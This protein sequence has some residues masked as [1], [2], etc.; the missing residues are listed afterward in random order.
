MENSRENN[1]GDKCTCTILLLLVLCTVSVIFANAR[2][3][4]RYTQNSF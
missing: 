3:G 1:D 4:P 2:P